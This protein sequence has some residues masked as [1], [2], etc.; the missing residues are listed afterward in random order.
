MVHRRLHRAL[1]KAAGAAEAAQAFRKPSPSK[2][3]SGSAWTGPGRRGNHRSTRGILDARRG[4][5]RVVEHV[6]TGSAPRRTM[7]SF[8]DHV[9]S[10]SDSDLADSARFPRRGLFSAMFEGCICDGLAL[11][12]SSS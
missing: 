6:D 3:E 10:R 9:T 2:S 5:A 8:A 4:S 11:D 12:A 7:V 1:H